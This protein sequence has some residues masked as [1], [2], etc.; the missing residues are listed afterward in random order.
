M[1]HP[2]IDRSDK[3][4][5]RLFLILG[6]LNGFLTVALGAFGAHAI[7]GQ[8]S[9]YHYDVFQTGVQYQGIHA[10]ALLVVGLL[11]FHV[12]S[13]WL[14]RAGWLFFTGI[15]LFSGSLYLLATVGS[16]PLGMITP[17]GGLLFLMG[18]GSLLIAFWQMERR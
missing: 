15:I 13:S 1:T 4:M 8:V 11:A 5:A 10:L 9:S 2:I 14:K 16:R 12:G 3:S 17:M 6:A 18:W 7:R